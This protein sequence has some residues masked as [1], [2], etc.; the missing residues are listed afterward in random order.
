M[1]R[2]E[3]AGDLNETIIAAMQG[4]QANIWTA[5]PCIVKSFNSVENTVIA[6]PALQAQVT[7]KDGT[8]Q[9]VTLPLLYDCPVI[10]PGGGGYSVTFK[11]VDGDEAVVVFASRCIDAWWQSSGI[12]QQAEL[13]MHDLSD[14]FAFVGVRSKPRAMTS[15]PEGITLYKED[16]LGFINL[17][18]D[19]ITIRSEKIVMLGDVTIHG[20]L[21]VPDD[22]AGVSFGGIEFKDH[23]HSGVESGSSDTG[24]VVI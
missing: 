1:D 19:T 3:R 6:Q 13:R 14:G 7:N 8:Y 21:D 4:N 18:N 10:F 20:S 12:Q 22:E 9:W 17:W 15:I 2:R 5:L 24:G 11:P 23:I 16:G